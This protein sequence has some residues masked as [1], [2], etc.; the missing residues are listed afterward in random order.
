MTLKA[1]FMASSIMVLLLVKSPRLTALWSTKT[2]YLFGKRPVM[3]H[4]KNTWLTFAAVRWPPVPYDPSMLSYV[5]C[6]RRIHPARCFSERF[7]ACASKQ[8]V[9]LSCGIKIA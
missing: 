5:R 3:H 8:A 1:R 4:F 7:P 6:V 9:E 2:I